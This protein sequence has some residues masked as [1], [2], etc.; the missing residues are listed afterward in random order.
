M[1]TQKKYQTLKQRLEVLN[2]VVLAFSGGTDST[3]LLK[4]AQ[5]VLGPENV[6][7][8]TA[9]SDIFPSQEVDV[10]RKLCKE[11]NA[12]C[13]FIDIDEMSNTEFTKNSE[14][15][16]Y[17][18]KREIFQRMRI[19]AD[20]KHIN[21]LIDGT[22]YD[23][24]IEGRPTFLVA[25]EIGVIHPL[26]EAKLTKQ[27]IRSLSRQLSLSTW[28]MVQHP[29]LASRFAEGITITKEG[30]NQI[31]ETEEIISDICIET[32][33]VYINPDSSV[34]LRLSEKDARKLSDPE[35][36]RK[37]AVSLKS[38]GFEAFS[39]DISDDKRRS[40]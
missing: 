16:C 14:K 10:A 21:V 28:D 13:F 3:L 6:I 2:S 26:A 25:R 27:E 34:R 35:M 1:N 33:L 22:N 40:R 37:I 32:P 18:C 8:V 24:Y 7:A 20:E 4:V 15:K 11:M 29:C 9:I 5:D 17:I 31:I 36:Q 19:I 39:V 38:V 23:D 30:I 12:C